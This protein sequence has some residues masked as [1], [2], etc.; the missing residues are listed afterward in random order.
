MFGNQKSYVQDS[1]T[2]MGRKIFSYII[3]G[4]ISVLPLALYYLPS[5]CA[6]LEVD[7]ILLNITIDKVNLKLSIDLYLLPAVLSTIIGGGGGFIMWCYYTR[8]R[9]LDE[10]V[11]SATLL[12]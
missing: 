11:P 6:Y 5:V 1:R 8:T 9:C 2:S 12:G 7:I 10:Q 3:L 4:L